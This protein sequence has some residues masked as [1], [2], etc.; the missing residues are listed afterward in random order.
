MHLS[1]IKLNLSSLLPAR[2]RKDFEGT[3][4][5][6]LLG[7]AV[8]MQLWIAFFV[9][10]PVA[11]YKL[12]PDAA[13]GLRSAVGDTV[14]YG[15]TMAAPL[16]VTLV[17]STL[18]TALRARRRYRLRHRKFSWRA[19]ADELFRLHPYGADD[20]ADYARPGGEDDKAANWIK[21]TPHSVNYLCGPSGA[22]KS[23]LVQAGLLPR[24]K[25]TDWRTVVVRVDK[26][27][28][29]R[30]RHAVLS[31]PDLPHDGKAE[32][33]QLSDLLEAVSQRIGRT[34]Q[35]PLLIVIDQFEE[36]LILNDTSDRQQLADILRRLDDSPLQ[37]IRLLLVFRSDY[38]GLLFKLKLPR[39]LPMENAFELAPFR[40]D[41][42][43]GFLER[44][45]LDM[46]DT[47][48]DALFQGLDRIEELHGL[49]RPITLNMVGLVMKRI[50]DYQIG[51]P[52]RLIEIYL[53]HCLAG[54]VS[55]DHAPN[56]LTCMMTVEGTKE[57]R[58]LAD[59]ASLTRLEAWEIDATLSEMGSAGLVRR[60]STDPDVWEISHDFLARQIGFLL[61][62]LRQPWLQRY[63]TLALVTATVS[64]AV[65]IAVAVLLILPA[66]KEKEALHELALMGFSRAAETRSH[67]LRLHNPYTLTNTN[68]G[69]FRDL[70]ADL[71]APVV[72]VHLPNTYITDLSPLKDLPLTQLNLT[73]AN[74]I[75]DLSPLKGLPLTQLDLFDADG[76][77]DLSPL[78]DLP[79]TQLNLTSA[80]GI[81]D[82]SP[83][84]GLPLT[85]LNL[86]F[87]DSITD[88]SPLK[89]LPLTYLNLSFADGIT[90]L[91]PLRDLPLKQL[92]LTSAR[93]ITDLSPLQ[94][95]DRS[96]IRGA[97]EELLATLN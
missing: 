32:T 19:G 11:L 73:S 7:Q 22:G 50:P 60:I 91:S 90:D 82:L 88:L 48:F 95:M 38:R 67:A 41:E 74:G 52:S 14:F 29:E 18:P 5:G 16:G 9:V 31:V 6:S 93:G 70:V 87:A 57:P 39:F 84:K 3:W 1:D 33:L 54:G 59:L 71:S 66:L 30:I 96:I 42:A 56:I 83:L 81:T 10:T 17:F 77:T 21:T 65:T 43:Q 92:H 20:E 72:E 44:G 4:L 12:L 13:E 34:D 76:I 78:K 97:S 37:G 80:N 68:F 28:V 79:L 75:T 8:I 35:L 2:A 27:P 45:G 64:W 55:R 36:F 23:S 51:D 47:G 61:G 86:S 89:G 53:R 94:G 49:Y 85:Q 46:E 15:V 26:D 63:A 62:R 69:R 25:A 58:R 40:R 24:L